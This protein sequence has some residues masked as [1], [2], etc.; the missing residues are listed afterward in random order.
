MGTRK[1]QRII[2]KGK[3]RSKKERIDGSMKELI[4]LRK[5]R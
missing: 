4:D 1:K 5:N 3:K 2:L